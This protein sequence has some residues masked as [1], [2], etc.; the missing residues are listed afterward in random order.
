MQSLNSNNEKLFLS[1]RE[2]LL[3]KKDP[4]FV[5]DNFPLFTTR[6]ELARYLVRYEIFKQ[7]IVCKGSIIECGVF[8]GSSLLFF[9]HLS[10]IME[11]FAY[12]REIIGFDTF[13][14]F[15]HVTEKDGSFA[16][17]GDLASADCQGLLRCISLFDDNRVISHI[18]KIKLVKCDATKTIPNYFNKNP[19]IIVSLLYLDFDLYEPTKIALHTILPRMPKGSII[20][21]DELNDSRR[22]GETIAIRENFGLLRKHKLKKFSFEPHISYIQL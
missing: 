15:P 17:K 11:P 9:A 5:A 18:P 14:G 19:H 21:F 10:A 4:L 12:N 1:K 16:Y 13:S 22:K 7:I 3:K 6:Q 20:A 2:K 8:N